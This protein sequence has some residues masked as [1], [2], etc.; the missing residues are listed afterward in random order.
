MSDKKAEEQ[1]FVERFLAGAKLDI[2]VRPGEA[3][4]FRLG[5]GAECVGLEVTRLF[6]PI[7]A[8][9]KPRQEIESLRGRVIHE[10]RSAYETVQG[11]LVHVSVLFSSWKHFGKSDVG[12]L[13]NALC[14][15]VVR[16]C[17]EPESRIEESYNALNQ[18]WFP[19]E[20][21]HITVW[22]LSSLV[23]SRV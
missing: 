1:Y 11:P 8:G 7:R 4:D 13:A 15:V 21:D 6:H 20:F 18:E 17:P 23:H 19:E 12:R 14:N 16:N 10:A 22:R 5:D 2:S 9:A 3:P